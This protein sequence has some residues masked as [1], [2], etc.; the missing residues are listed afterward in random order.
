MSALAAFTAWPF[1]PMTDLADKLPEGLRRPVCL[2]VA[3]K[4]A[5][6]SVASLIMAAT[7]LCVVVLRYGFQADLF[8]YNEW[9]LIICFWLFFMGGALGTYEGSHISADL[10]SYVTDSPRVAWARGLLVTSIELVISIAI[11]YWAILMI[12]DEI[13]SY[14]VWQTT[15]A[16]KIPFIVPRLGILVGFAF[17]TF[18]TALHLYVLIRLRPGS[19]RAGA[20]D[21]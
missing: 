8:A 20:I 12:N 9:L 10:L 19:R 17:M 16:L 7:F 15:V 18:Y 1:T 14:P 6:V 5:F 2:M 3:A 11:V 21:H 13:A 4:G